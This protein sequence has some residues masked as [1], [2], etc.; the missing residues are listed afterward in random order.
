[1]RLPRTSGLLLHPTSLPSRFGIGDLGPSALEFLALL[2][3]TGQRWWQILPI[4]PTGFGNSPYQSYSSYAGNPLLI[5][6]E[7]LA[8]TGWISPGDWSDY[9]ALPDDR[10]DFDAVIAAKERLLRRAFAAAQP[11][12]ADFSAFVAVNDNW[13]ADY[14][15]YMALKESHGGSAWYDWEPPYGAR[16]PDALATARE[17]LDESIRYFEFVQYVFAKQWASIRSACARSRVAPDGRPADLRR[18]G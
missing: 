5:S 4:G 15:L 1:M 2:E 16:D 7:R 10:V 17:Q 18:S 9:P 12:P 14:A 11:L 8:E 13:L 6:P 3:E